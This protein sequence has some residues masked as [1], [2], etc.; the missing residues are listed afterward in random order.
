MRAEL[1][2]LLAIYFAAGTAIALASRR[3]G[4]RSARDYFIAGGRMGGL[5]LGATYAATT[6]S[7]FMMIG[8]VGLAYKTGAGA[9]GFE[10]AYL[11]STVAIL[12]TAGFS[13]WRASRERGWVS[14]SECFGDLSGD[15]WLARAVALLYLVATVPYTASQVIGISL[16]L[17]SAGLGRLWAA[18]ASAGL[19]YAWMAIAGLWSVATTDLFQAAWM[20]AG[21]LAYAAWLVAGLA[22]SLGA[23]PGRV[24]SALL[25]SQYAGV[26]PFWAPHVFAAY[27]LPWLFFSLS[28][29][30]VLQ[31]L[32]AARDERSLR[33]MLKYFSAFGFSYTLLS[34]FVGLFARGLTLLGALPEVPG[35][36]AVTPALL[37]MADPWLASFVYVSI[38]AAAVSTANGI[39]LSVASS[40]FS[41]LVPARWRRRELAA[42]NAASLAL[43]AAASAFAYYRP[44]YIVDL[45]VLTSS[46]LLPLAPLLLLLMASPGAAKRG[47]S[48]LLL[49]ASLA[50]G[51]APPL[52]AWLAGG[53]QAV[54]SRAY[55]GLPVQA[56]SLLLSTP[57]AAAAIFAGRRR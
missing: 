21:G 54:F 11:V 12:S 24:A 23:D 50:A 26:T 15:P 18:L 1:A 2:A 8:L 44:G 16:I 17:E 33:A 20:A 40:V 41:E 55:W 48:R 9:L 13:I 3:F 29:P 35:R 52:W 10:L 51:V 49:H 6:Y 14:P 42:S 36:D 56:L 19:V 4:V 39:V 25:S 47:A 22:P 53:I 32:F 34:V 31:K 30:Q 27:T 7:A 37:S 45:S 43:T 5:L 38:V 28:N 57:L 46:I